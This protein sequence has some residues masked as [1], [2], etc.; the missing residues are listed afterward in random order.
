MTLIQTCC[1]KDMLVHIHIC[2]EQRC[3]KIYLGGRGW[4]KIWTFH[5]GPKNLENEK[6]LFFGRRNLKP[7]S[8][9]L[10]KII[11]CGVFRFLAKR[12][13]NQHLRG[14]ETFPMKKLFKQ[15]SILSWNLLLLKS[16]HQ[17]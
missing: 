15:N 12:K 6:V 14:K 7:S 11:G 13:K 1:M 10:E 8:W 4:Q 16:C 5:Q 3:L 9:K 17:L 2:K